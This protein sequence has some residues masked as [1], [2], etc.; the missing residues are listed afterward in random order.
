[1]ICAMTSPAV[2]WLLESD[3]LAIRRLTRRDLLHEPGGPAA[4]DGPKVEALL[5]GLD[6]DTVHPYRKWEGAHWRLV[7]LVELE[8]TDDERVHGAAD[9]V[10]E[11]LTGEKH[12]RSIRTVDGLARV[13]ASMEGNALVV[14]C[15]LGMRDDAR[16]ARIAEDLIAWQWPDGGWNCDPRASGRRSSFH[17]S[18]IPMHGLFEYG[19]VDAAN[20]TAELLLD[21]RLYRRRD[22][23]EPIHAEWVRLH[24]PPRWHYDI[25]HALTV[26][27]R[28]GRATDPRAEDALDILSNKRLRN[29]RWRGDP[30]ITLKALRVLHQRIAASSTASPK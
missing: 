7:E 22:T 20:R 25:L 16:V 26:L 13:H 5:D 23:G 12:R 29:G 8:A 18:L 3:E 17:E 9:R 6:D 4:M 19:A 24:H 15:A 2:Q 28:M 10:L 30:M 11:W 1:M 21:H 14:C 27:N